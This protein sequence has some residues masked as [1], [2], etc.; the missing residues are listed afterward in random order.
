MAVNERFYDD[1]NFLPVGSPMPAPH[2]TGSLLGRLK[3]VT[4]DRKAQIAGIRNWLESHDPSPALLRSFE[5]RGYQ[6]VL[7]PS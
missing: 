5:R 2:T 6:E 7:S 3:L 4:A 1:S